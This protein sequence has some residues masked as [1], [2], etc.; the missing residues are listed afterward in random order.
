MENLHIVTVATEPKYY[1][2]YL[3]ESCKRHGKELTVLGF[4]EKWTGFNMKF[5]LMIDYLQ[6][7]PET[8]IVCFID[9]Y[10]V[11]CVRDLNDFKDEFI[12][13]KK[14]TGCK[15]M[16]AEDK[17]DKEVFYSLISLI[18][19]SCKN[20]NINSG[21]YVGF[22]KDILYALKNI[23]ETNNN[24]KED[25]QILLT[26]Y[27]KINPDNIYID[28]KSELFFTKPSP[29][30]EIENSLKIS[31]KD[32][33]YKNNKPFFIHAP[34]AGYLDSLIIKMGYYYD[35]EKKI[36]DDV[37]YGVFKD[38]FFKSE[39][40]NYFYYLLIFILIVIGVYYFSRLKYFKKLL[41]RVVKK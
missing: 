28:S 21:T 16:V 40:Y 24:D 18:F 6:Q 3:V 34:A 37:F 31:N 30:S 13:I 12:R 15:I 9:G 4:G 5:R 8:D 32:V 26:R 7:L 29:F 27:C 25:D 19:G 14:E 2:H 1:F 11:L 38:K 41:H 20:K 36:K 35:N 23:R 17:I 22:V 39:F 33:Y 10:D